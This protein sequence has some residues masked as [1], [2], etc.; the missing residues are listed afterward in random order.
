M[1]DEILP[2]LSLNTNE[3]GVGGSCI[4]NLKITKKIYEWSSESSGGEWNSS[5][6]WLTRNVIDF[7]KQQREFSTRFPWSETFHE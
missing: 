2:E 3:L 5:A 7:R 1:D 6:I 4:P